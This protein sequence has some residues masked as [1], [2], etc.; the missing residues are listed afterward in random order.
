METLRLLKLAFREQAVVFQI[1]KQCDLSVEGCWMVRTSISKEIRSKCRLSA[2]T[3]PQN[4]RITIHEV[5]NMLAISL[6]SVQSI[7]KDSLIVLFIAT[8]NEPCLLVRCRRRSMVTCVRTFTGGFK[9][10]RISLWCV[11][12][13]ETADGITEKEISDN[14]MIKQHCRMHLLSFRPCASQNALNNTAVKNP[15]DSA[16]EQ[17]TLNRSQV[18]LQ[19]NEFSPGTV[20]SHCICMHDAVQF[21]GPHTEGGQGRTLRKMKWNL[22]QFWCV[23]NETVLIILYSFL[24]GVK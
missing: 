19:A 8:Q 17:T 11:S 14:T 12:F 13:S 20:W 3:C 9:R 23:V 16:L 15:K 4:R 5:V 7:W 10:P 22:Q 2:E 24:Y 18:L 1:K 6:W 21:V